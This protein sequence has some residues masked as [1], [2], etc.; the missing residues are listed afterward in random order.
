VKAHLLDSDEPLPAGKDYM[1]LCGAKVSKA[2]FIWWSDLEAMELE[3]FFIYSLRFCRYCK[4]IIANTELEKR[5]LYGLID[6]EKAKHL[7]EADET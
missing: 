1:A 7:G 5:Y 4:R 6:G 2:A 3:D